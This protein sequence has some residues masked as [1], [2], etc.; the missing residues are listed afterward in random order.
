MR[1]DY[2]SQ[3]NRRFADDDDLKEFK[4]RLYT[5]IKKIPNNVIVDGYEAYVEDFPDYMPAVI[6]LVDYIYKENRKFLKSKAEKERII[7]NHNQKKIMRQVNPI[8]LLAKAKLQKNNSNE[9]FADMV[10]AHNAIISAKIKRDATK[11]KNRH[12]GSTCNF[13]DC[14]KPGTTSD[15]LRGDRAFYCLDHYLAIKSDYG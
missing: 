15:G 14:N 7:E 5:K 10:A 13:S 3:F 1:A 8:E 6:K 2:G 12:Q 4:N 11:T 9:S